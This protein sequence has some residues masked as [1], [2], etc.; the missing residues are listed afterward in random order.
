MRY[1]QFWCSEELMWINSLDGKTTSRSFKLVM[2]RRTDGCDE[3][4]LLLL[5]RM[6]NTALHEAAA[7]GSEGLRSAEILLR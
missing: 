5:L 2:K 7:L 4:L 6:K 1:F 3:Q